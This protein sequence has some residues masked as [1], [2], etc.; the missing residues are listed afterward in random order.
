MA[1]EPFSIWSG[2]L[3][4]TSGLITS[5]Q[6]I[7]TLLASVAQANQLSKSSIL[8]DVT[9]YDFVYASSPAVPGWGLRCIIE[10]QINGLWRPVGVQFEP[11]RD[12]AQ[13]SRQQIIIQPN[14]VN[15]DEGIPID[16]WNGLQVASRI[17]RQQGILGGGAWR[18][19]IQGFDSKF[20][21]SEALTSFKVDLVGERYDA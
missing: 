3:V 16:V 12:P 18:I 17:N 9:Y 2:Q 10:S 1:A 5:N 20:G 15:F 7:F 14:I 13:G 21:T 8:V 19:V 6:G 11:L 4:T